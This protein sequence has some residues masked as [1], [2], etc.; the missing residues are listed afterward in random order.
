MHELP[1]VTLLQQSSARPVDGDELETF[2]KHAASLYVGGQRPTLNDAVVEVVKHAGLSPEQVRRVIEF[3]NNDAYLQ[4]F[5][6]AGDHRVI[7]FQGGPADPGVV[8]R[9]LN[10]GGGGTVF[11]DGL[12]DYRAPPA[13]SNK[14]AAM[15]MAKLG[16][17]QRFTD[18]FGPRAPD[19]AYAEPFQDA[20]EL[21]DKLASIVGHQ[22]SVLNGLER[23]YANVCDHLCGLVKQAVLDDQ[24]SLGQVVQA[25]AAV[26]DDPEYVKCAFATLTP[27]LL[28]NQV[29]D[30]RTQI[31][32][33]IER[34]E[35]QAQIVQTEHPLCT[36]FADYCATLYK[37]AETRQLVDETTRG[38]DTLTEFIKRAAA[39]PGVLRSAGRAVK[40]M[41]GVA[42]GVSGAAA[43]AAEQALAGTPNAAKVVSTGLRATPYL[44]AGA[45]ALKT[46]E[47]AEQS[48][49]YW[50]L[51]GLMPNFGGPQ[52]GY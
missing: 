44:G 35:K 28:D 32:G 6:Q 12:G 19:L 13:D 48:P 9:D 26:Q 7:E 31:A 38:V 14:L 8:L 52:M 34:L 40:N 30:S 37:L 11:D 22:S 43:G 4:E 46:K 10:D 27:W 15:N 21:R 39:E 47:K 45:L 16:A 2:G 23:R 50:R 24:L 20:L 3:A 33:S 42:K 41:W 5:K 18:Q 36:T 51:R 17:D 49:T 25:W 1:A 29:F